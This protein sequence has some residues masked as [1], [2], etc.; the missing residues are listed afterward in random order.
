MFLPEA[1]TAPERRANVVAKNFIFKLIS[2]GVI[3]SNNV[4]TIGNAM[5][6]GDNGSSEAIKNIMRLCKSARTLDNT[7]SLEEIQ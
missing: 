1:Y 3:M 6:L 7:I 2:V 5:L 4:G